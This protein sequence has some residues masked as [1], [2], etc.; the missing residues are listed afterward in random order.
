MTIIN[1]RLIRVA[2]GLSLDELGRRAGIE[3]TRL[4]RFERQYQK[5]RPEEIDRLAKELETTPKKLQKE[6]NMSH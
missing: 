2:K 6:M 4:S 5:L 3:R 1:A